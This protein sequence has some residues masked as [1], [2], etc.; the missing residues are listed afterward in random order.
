M[1]LPAYGALLIAGLALAIAA[2]PALAQETGTAGE[3]EAVEAPVVDA[4]A[5][6][7]P[8]AE[9]APTT[10]AG[11]ETAQAPAQEVLEVVK[12]TH[13]DWEVRCT[14]EGADCFMYQLAMDSENNPVAEFSL[15]RLA[16][17]AGVAAGAT[18]VSPLGTLLPAGVELQIDDGEARRYPFTW[19]S[20]VGCFARFGVEAAAITSMKA[21]QVAK[22][23]LVSVAAPDRPLILEVSLSGFTAA[24]DSLEPATAPN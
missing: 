24:F 11:S 23:V 17:E 7:A 3:A 2:E 14:P 6:E 8:A 21:G 22:A 19:C 9:A 16:D 20:Q 4:P 10:P 13:G 15:V 1:T 12:A 5:A 18:V